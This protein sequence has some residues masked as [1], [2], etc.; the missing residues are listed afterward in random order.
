LLPINFIGIKLAYYDFGDKYMIAVI[1]S[2]KGK[3]KWPI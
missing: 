2:K 3:A 1:L